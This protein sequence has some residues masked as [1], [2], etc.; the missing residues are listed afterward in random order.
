MQI[1]LEKD[2]A[3]KREGK[4]DGE[5]EEEKIEVESGNETMPI[6]GNKKDPHQEVTMTYCKVANSFSLNKCIFY[7]VTRHCRC[8]LGKLY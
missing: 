5:E 6:N 8:H 2:V 3:S 4:D 7:N 1:P